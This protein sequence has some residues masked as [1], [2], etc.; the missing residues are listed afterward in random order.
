MQINFE[1]FLYTMCAVV[2]T[3]AGLNAEILLQRFERK[4]KGDGEEG[5]DTRSQPE[6]ADSQDCADTCSALSDDD[7]VEVTE[8]GRVS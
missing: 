8:V 3:L 1:Q 2:R 4:A 7:V 5:S 6:S